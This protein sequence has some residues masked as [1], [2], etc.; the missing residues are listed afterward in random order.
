[1]ED[2]A[3]VATKPSVSLKHSDE[4]PRQITTTDTLDHT[5][6]FNILDNDFKRYAPEPLAPSD[7]AAVEQGRRLSGMTATME[8]DGELCP[9]T[10]RFMD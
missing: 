10:A 4:N 5:A 7:L 2:I 6:E 3:A 8:H 1:M 9:E